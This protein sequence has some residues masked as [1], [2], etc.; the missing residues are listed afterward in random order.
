MRRA[1]WGGTPSE[2]DR[3]VDEGIDAT[4]ARLLDIGAAPPAGD[5]HHSPGIDGYKPPDFMVWWYHL[6]VSSPTPGIERLAWFWHGHFR[7]PP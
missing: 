2:I 3:G 6:A 1:G 4:V 5:A 7:H